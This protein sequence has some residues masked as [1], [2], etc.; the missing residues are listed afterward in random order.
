MPSGDGDATQYI[1][2]VSS[3][4][5]DATQY[6][7][8]VSAA[9]DDATRWIEP[10]RDPAGGSPGGEDPFGDAG[11][12]RVLPP[13]PAGPVSRSLPGPVAGKR[14]AARRAALPAPAPGGRAAARR[15]ARREGP[16]GSGLS[17]RALAVVVIAGCAVAGLTAG[18]VFGGGDSAAAGDGASSE[19]DGADPAPFVD[20]P[21]P[22]GGAEEEPEPEPEPEHDPAAVAARAEALSELLGESVG[23]R[24]AVVAAVGRIEE[25]KKL[26][27]AAETLRG[28]AGERTSQVMR[29]HGMSLDGLP[30]HRELS[31]ALTEAWEASADADDRYADWALEVR[32]DRRRMCRRGETRRTDNTA[33]A[34]RAGAEATAA[35]ERAAELWNPIAREHGLP[36]RSAGDL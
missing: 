19:L 20:G 13:I 24:E 8:P 18:A 23:S 25:C 17:T 16:F 33:E 22:A 36:E 26:K 2:P 11:A 7:P 9:P 4:D 14:A 3:G 29:L 5:G 10:V 34:E 27:E 12:T 30:E 35:K 28:A 6:I 31:R 21:D 1:P 32:E 15:A